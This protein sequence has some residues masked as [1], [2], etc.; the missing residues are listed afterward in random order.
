MIMVG[1]FR[2]LGSLKQVDFANWREKF[3]NCH[4]YER[5]ICA[6]FFV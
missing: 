6:I 5:V 1:N 3:Q 4:L 2:S